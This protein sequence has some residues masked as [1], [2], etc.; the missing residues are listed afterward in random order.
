M[1]KMVSF[2]GF[3]NTGISECYE[4]NYDHMRIFQ[5][6]VLFSLLELIQDSFWAV[7]Y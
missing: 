3:V 1:I 7:P 4:E 6:Y 2:L 5:I